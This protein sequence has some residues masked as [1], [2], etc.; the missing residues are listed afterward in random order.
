MAHGSNEEGDGVS[1][2]AYLDTELA[3]K[4][5]LREWYDRIWATQY[6]EERIKVIRATLTRTVQQ[7]TTPVKGGGTSQ[8]D[9]LVNGI[10]AIDKLTAQ[11][12]D[13]DEIQK[14]VERCWDALTEGE[15][16]LLRE[17]YIDNEDRQGIERIK[18]ALAIEK[19]EAYKRVNRAL[20]RLSR[21]LFW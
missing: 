14:E 8:E 10:S 18:D 11:M 1:I 2:Y 17:M 12:H 5:I 20:E 9:K 16:F 3:T 6:A 15:R 4:K 13:A 21:L 19:S 7:G